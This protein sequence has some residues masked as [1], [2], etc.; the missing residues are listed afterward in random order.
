[1]NAPALIGLAVVAVGLVIQ[2]LLLRVPCYESPGGYCRFR[3]AKR[4]GGGVY[5]SAVGIGW[6]IA[7]TALWWLIFL[8]PIFLIAVWFGGKKMPNKNA[9]A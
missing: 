4:H 2:W 8:L 9:V 7:I 6:R 3:K 1:V 5:H